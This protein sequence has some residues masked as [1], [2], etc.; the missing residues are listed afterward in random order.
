MTHFFFSSIISYLL[1]FN[2]LQVQLI[3]NNADKLSILWLFWINT[4]TLINFCNQKTYL[5]LTWGGWRYI[6][7][8]DFD[9][10]FS[11]S[12]TLPLFLPG[13][14]NSEKLSR[15]CAE[16]NNFIFL[17]LIIYL[18]RSNTELFIVLYC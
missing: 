4:Q 13:L 8:R 16:I 18:P 2:H 5:T 1:Y 14:W 12:P 10:P 9:L 6:F 3:Y 15:N 11:P 17:S 7:K